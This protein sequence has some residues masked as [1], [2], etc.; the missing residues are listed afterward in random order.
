[1]QFRSHHFRFAQH[2]CNIGHYSYVKASITISCQSRS[3]IT[4]LSRTLLVVIQRLHVAFNSV[5]TYILRLSTLPLFGRHSR[6][7]VEYVIYYVTEFRAHKDS[8]NALLLL[9]LTSS[10]LFCIAA[11]AGGTFVDIRWL[12]KK[13]AQQNRESHE[14]HNEHRFQQTVPKCIFNKINRTISRV[15]IINS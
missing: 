5:S 15:S 9:V 12:R 14:A 3:D 13:K 7:G 10:Q 6:P 4:W 11:N 8:T 2:R 1:M